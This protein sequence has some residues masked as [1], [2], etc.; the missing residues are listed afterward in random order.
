MRSL[1]LA[2]LLFLAAPGAAWAADA[3]ITSQDLP[4]GVV[5]SPAAAVAPQRFDLVAFHWQGS[6]HVL[7]RTRS[8]VGRW[9]GW[10]RAAPEG[11]DLPDPA[12]IEARARPGWE[13]GNPYW[14]GPSDRIA[15]W[16]VGD[17]RRLRAWYVW[18]P[19]SHA[20]V[21][22]VSMAGSPQI[23]PRSEW[24]ANEAIKRAPPRYAKAVTLA[25]VHHTAGTNAY[26][27][28]ASAAIV[29]AI[30]L[31]H[32]RGNHWNDIGYNFLVDRYGQVFEGRAGGIDRNVIGAQ[33]QG[34]NTGS[35]GIALIGNYNTGNVMSA[36]RKAL[37]SLLAWRLDVAHVD[38]LGTV[39]WVSGG[40]PKY[41]AGKTVALR[42]ISGHRDTGFT[43]C[44]GT[45]LYSQLPSIAADVAATG[46]P[47]L[48]APVVKGSL[49]GPITFVARLSRPGGW[50]VTVRDP[51][52]TVVARGTGR[53]AAIAWTW[54]STG[55]RGGNY[56]WT[57]EAGAAT[58]PAQGTFGRAPAPAPTP[59]PVPSFL[60]ALTVDPPVISPDGDGVA[61]ALTISYRL[62]VRASV[63]TTVLDATGAV[64]A[65]LFS[66]QLE[67]ARTQSFPY[68][69]PGL[70]DGNYTLTV[71]AVTEDGRTAHEQVLFAIDRTLTGL[72]LSTATLTPNG[73]GLDDSLEVDFTLN[74]SAEVTVQIEQNGL[75]VAA[76]YSGSLSPGVQ[77]IAWDG[78]SA[79][80]LLPAGAYVV[81]VIV[82]GPFG[83]TRH[84]VALTIAN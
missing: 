29:R 26:G 72:M 73:D 76:V 16:L 5:R 69:A 44:P 78:T 8:Q 19:V 22:R 59:V 77:S 21:R 23:V 36:E 52:G 63:T 6:G 15:F 83:E 81:A 40:N 27:P 80:K 39:D 43:S 2:L 64:A 66:A 82:R 79:G 41:R 46:L 75:N 61:D 68:A 49:G 33:A 70:A 51:G 31:Y 42:A 53:G 30:E 50:T 12:S 55:R 58:R 56:T 28:S 11:E 34:F 20:A 9:S 35:V 67:G 1:R 54:N 14:V 32:V 13:V 48:Y 57:M 10:R 24:Q 65:T 7:F 47:K 71:D 17:V 37:V 18:S 45:R 4:I 62:A 74:A 60:S 38:P 25:I 3:R 84:E